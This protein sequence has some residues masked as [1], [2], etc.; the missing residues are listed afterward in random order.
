MVNESFV[1]RYLGD[2]D[3]IGRQLGN[4]GGGPPKT[5][6]GVVADTLLFGREN[7]AP[8]EIY[9][10]LSSAVSNRFQVAVKVAGDPAAYVETLRRVL[11][12]FDPNMPVLQ[13]RSMDAVLAGGTE[14]RR[15]NLQ[16]MLVFGAVALGLAALGIYAVIAYSVAQRR[17]EFGIRMSLGADSGRILAL[18]L[19]QGMRL[20]SLGLLLGIGGAVVLGRML[21]SQLFGVGSG[22]PWVIG[23]VT[24]LLAAVALAACAV[25]ALRA[26]RIAPMVALTAP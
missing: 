16:L 25:P 5:I 20:A 7:E 22:D 11:R 14:L 1:R 19:A 8:P 21:S 10:P 18:V 3:P 12:E 15:F 23:I 26:S 4:V 2:G 9:M 13:V 6:V 24:A 17:H